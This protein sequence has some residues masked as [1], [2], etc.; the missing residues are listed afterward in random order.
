MGSVYGS[1][2]R[3]LCR[4]NAMMASILCTSN[5][6]FHHLF[7][8][9]LKPLPPYLL[10]FSIQGY[11]LRQDMH[12]MT[13]H[14]YK[15]SD[16]LFKKLLEGLFGQLPPFLIPNF[17][18]RSDTSQVSFSISSKYD[19]SLFLRSLSHLLLLLFR[20]WFNVHNR[21]PFLRMCNLNPRARYHGGYYLFT[22]FL[23]CMF[24]EHGYFQMNI[25]Y[26]SVI[27]LTRYYLNSVF[28]PFTMFYHFIL[29]GYQTRVVL[30]GELGIIIL[31]LLLIYG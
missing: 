11:S 27:A 21:A 28:W 10:F 31:V 18:H 30:T 7:S 8:T 3:N 16:I 2:A 5:P 15:S 1:F 20:L 6:L 14:I 4:E 12:Q 19:L 29:H 22:W 9:S 13:K 25:L 26:I 24:L 23:L 17:D